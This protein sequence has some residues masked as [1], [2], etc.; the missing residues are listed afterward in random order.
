MAG[1]DY[2]ELIQH[3]KGVRHIVI[4]ACHGGFG[5]SRDA[6]LHYLERAGIA[7]TL[8]ERED[9]HSTLTKGP[10][11]MVN[12]NHWFDRHIARDDPAL[13]DVVRDLGS[14]ANGRHAELKIVT[15]PADV[16]WQIDEY[17]GQEWVAEKHRT[18][19]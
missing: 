1:Q 4:N 5:L 15:I 12:G 13:V 8:E 3:L 6:E 19:S 16:E 17:D 2:K 11:I 10:Y 18:W 9:R 14:Q 7:Y